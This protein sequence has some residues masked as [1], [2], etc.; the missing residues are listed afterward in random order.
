MSKYNEGDLVTVKLDQNDA[1]NLN[2]GCRFGAF[3]EKQ[4]VK[5]EPAPFNWDEVKPGMAFISGSTVYWYVGPDL[6]GRAF[7][8]LTSDKRYHSSNNNLMI[9][10]SVLTRAPEHDITVPE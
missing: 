7:A 2:V 9:K 8:L 5:H 6:S 1:K 10:K 3:H 4:I